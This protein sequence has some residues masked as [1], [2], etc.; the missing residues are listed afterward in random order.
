[1]IGCQLAGLWFSRSLADA[2]YGILKDRTN[3]FE[4]SLFLIQIEPMTILPDLSDL[5]IEQVSI[6]NDVMITVRAASP[7]V[8]C[9][10]CGTLSRRVQSRYT[11]TLRDLP[12]SGR[13]THLTVHVRR[14]FCQ[15]STCIRKIFAERFPS[16][17]LPRVKFTLRLQETLRQMGFALGGEAGARLGRVLSIPGSSDTVLRLVKQ[18]ELPVASSPR[19]VGIDDWSWKRRLRYGTL[20]CDLE[21]RKPIDVLPDRS[22][23]SVSAWFEKYPSIEIVSRDRS[24]E[25]AAAIKKGAPQALQ[26]ADLWHIGKNLAESVST[27]LARCRAEIR[28]GLHVQAEPSQER[29]EM[30]PVSEE[31]RHPARSLSE[32]QARV[33]RRAQKLDRYEQ[34]I[35]LHDQG[36]KAA[37]IASRTGISGR[38]VQRWLAHGSFPEARRRRRRPSLIDPYERSVLQW[39]HEGNRNGLQL[40]RELITRGYKG[41]SKAMYNYLATLRTPQ[42]DSLQSIPLKLRRRKSVPLLPPP[43][44]N[45]SAQRATWLFVCQPEKLDQIQQEELMRILQ[46][47]PS[48]ETAYSLAQGFMQMIRE[49]TGQPLESWLNAVEESH[50]P[51]LKSF[52]RGIQHDKAA[53]LAGL[54]LSWSQGPLEGHVNRLKLIKRSM[55]GRAKLPLLRARVLHV[56]EKE[57][58]RATILAG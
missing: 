20:I 14:F 38:T 15:E 48:A 34:I 29:E 7:M 43:L 40:Y 36:L 6:T 41:S 21:S 4:Q 16:L 53:V 35:E 49:H 5:I 18:T 24:S 58:A 25:Y 37:E 47:S 39:W 56:A 1:M 10:C 11:R 19:V 2:K 42:S 52:A 50:L 9:P 28:R 33:A 26:V 45:F 32:E 12:V 22:V 44:E 51:E 30:E 31:E 27:L 57:P 54:T 46:A 17:T 13:Y 23:E 8:P 3:F 55:Y